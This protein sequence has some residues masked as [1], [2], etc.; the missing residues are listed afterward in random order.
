M[1]K[2]VLDVLTE[3]GIIADDGLICQ[4]ETMK[5]HGPD[6]MIIIQI[7][8]IDEGETPVL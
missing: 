1:E 8:S 7:F 2:G 6:P 3:V 4:K 5:M